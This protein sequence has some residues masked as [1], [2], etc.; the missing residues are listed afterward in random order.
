MK[1]YQAIARAIDARNNCTT[2]PMIGGDAT[3]K[4]RV[5][6]WTTILETLEKELPRGSGFDSGSKISILRSKENKLVL[7]TSFHHM[8][9]NGVYK[10][11][12]EHDVVVTP[13]FVQGFNLRVTGRD[14]NS[15]KEY[16]ESVFYNSL[17]IEATE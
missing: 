15:I 7:H 3:R 12:S 17:I 9:S 13:D 1:V 8:N 10:E 6:T 5:A 4:K 14:R 2:R 16:I 11:W